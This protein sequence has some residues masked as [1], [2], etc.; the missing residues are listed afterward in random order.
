M[1]DQG[2]RRGDI[3]GAR[4]LGRREADVVARGGVEQSEAAQPRE[5]GGD[6][7][8]RREQVLVSQ[9]A[10][11]GEPRRD[12]FVPAFVALWGTHQQRT[13]RWVE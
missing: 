11:V 9:G 12:G 2:K 3:S 7:V 8:Q 13:K 4:Y 6:A 5:D 10:E 1:A